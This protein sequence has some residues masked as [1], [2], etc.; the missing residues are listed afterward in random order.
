M[1]TRNRNAVDRAIGALPVVRAARSYH[2]AYG[3]EGG[4]LGFDANR[5]R[6]SQSL[7][8]AVRLGRSVSS[9]DS[10]QALDRRRRLESR[11]RPMLTSSIDRGSGARESSILA[12]SAAD[13]SAPANITE[14]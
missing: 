7:S 14:S 2:G 3:L 13:H 12:T 4:Y 10:T 9:H 1:A 11:P 8:S 6:N 5:A